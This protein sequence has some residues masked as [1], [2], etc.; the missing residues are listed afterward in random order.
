MH[1]NLAYYA[2]LY[3]VSWFLFKQ[4]AKYTAICPIMQESAK[5]YNIIQNY[6]VMVHNV[7]GGIT[8]WNKNLS[9]SPTLL[10]YVHR[11]YVAKFAFVVS[12]DFDSGIFFWGTDICWGWRYWYTDICLAIAS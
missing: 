1:L 7:L 6:V 9:S 11:S 10:K 4:K 2:Y 12:N 5:L 3:N 8:N